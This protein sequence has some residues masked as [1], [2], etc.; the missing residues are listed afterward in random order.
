MGAWKS[1][2]DASCMWTTTTE[3][4]RVVTGERVLKGFSSGHKGI[5]W[6]SE[7]VQEK[8][9]AKKATYLKLIES[10][11]E[12][13]KR[14]NKE[15]YRRAKKEA[16]LAVIAAK[17]AAY[18]HLYEELGAKGG[19]KKIP[20]VRERK[21]RYLDQVKCIKD[22]EG[23]EWLTR[24]FNVIFKTKKMPEEWRQSTMI[25]LYKNKGDI[26][27]FNNYMGINLLSHTM[28]VL[29]RVVEARVRSSM[30]IS[31][32]QFDFMSGSSTME[33]IHLVRRLVE[34]YREMKKDFHMVF[35]NLEKAYDKVPREVAGMLVLQLSYLRALA[36]QL[37]SIQ[38]GI[39]YRIC[40]AL[41]IIAKF[42][43]R[44]DPGTSASAGRQ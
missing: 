30:S 20:K 7:G 19:D 5:W 23:L 14:M 15:G 4:I 31:E 10:M 2:E 35:I 18:G 17:T 26:Q 34:W 42:G 27:S 8:V 44:L 41:L 3:C 33:A 11:D 40:D 6:W 36:S 12:K 24:P 37:Q 25:P 9:E 22:E 38:G 43:L 16:K 21:A 13:A 28:K 29:E 1:S 39:K 32:N